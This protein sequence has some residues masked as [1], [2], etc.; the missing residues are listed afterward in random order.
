MAALLAENPDHHG[1]IRDGNCTACHESHAGDKFRLLKESY[2]AEFYAPFDLDTF[3]LCFRCHISD[4]VLSKSGS[5][6][7]QFRDGDRNLH[8]LHVNRAKGRTCRSCHEVHASKRPAHIREAVPF[9]TG[10]WMLPINF[11][12]TP[13]GGSCMPGCHEARTYTR[14]RAEAGPEP[15]ERFG[16]NPPEESFGPIQEEPP[17]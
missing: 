15:V 2:P 3:K 10:E 17:P 7:T 9:G 8:F 13:D 5:G 12:K 14:T 1:P 6:L 11:Q 4:L 16:P